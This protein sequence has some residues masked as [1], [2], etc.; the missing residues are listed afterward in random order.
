[1]KTNEYKSP[2]AALL[3]SVMMAGFGQ[4][5]NGQYIFGFVLLITEFSANIAS[6]LNLAIHHSIHGD[7]LGAHNVV[8][9]QWGLF[10]PSV[11]VFSIWQAYNKAILMNHQRKGEEP[12]PRTYLTGFCIGLVAGMNFGVYWHHHFLDEISLIRFLTSPVHN[13][14]ALGV[15]GGIVGHLIEKYVNNRAKDKLKMR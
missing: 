9:Y 11:Y 6:N 7:F 8:D 1:M 2:V 5:Y 14:L 12:Q 3:W 10:Y 4:F 15:I 13:G